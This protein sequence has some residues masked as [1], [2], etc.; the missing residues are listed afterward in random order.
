[1]T[2]PRAQPLLFPDAAPTPTLRDIAGAVR[3][4]GIDALPGAIERADRA[5]YQ[6][7]QV[8]TG[9]ARATGMPFRWTLNPYRGCTHACEYCFARKYQRHLELDADDAFSSFILV[10]RNLPD[11][12]QREVER[13]SWL[14]EL[15]A[16]GTATDPYQPIEG[17]YRITRR[18]LAI[19]ASSRTPFSLVT[20]GPMVVRDVDVLA[21]AARGAGCQ[22]FMSVPSVDARAWAALEP[23]TAAP[24]QRLRATRVLQD[25]GVDAAV[26][27]MPLVPGVTTSKSGIERTASAVEAAGLRVA[28][29][30]VARFDPGAREHFFRFLHRTYPALLAGYRRLYAGAHAP[31]AYVREVKSAVTRALSSSGSDQTGPY[32]R[33]G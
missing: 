25:A 4:A 10:K 33:N 29:A 11:V 30:G 2:P 28:G 13:T 14:R 12:L 23:G 20:K 5:R 26:L 8:R 1:M 3:A 27:M 22:V 17:H 16:V 24:E 19:L 15:V 6:E 31:A 18:C 9:L 21:A 7:V 32:N